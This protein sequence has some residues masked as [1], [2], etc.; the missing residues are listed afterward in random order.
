MTHLQPS[1]LLLPLVEP[2]LGGLHLLPVP[3]PLLLPALLLQPVLRLQL[4]EAGQLL[5]LQGQRALLLLLQQDVAA[6]AARQRGALRQRGPLELH[7]AV[8]LGDDG[9]GNGRDQG[10]THTHTQTHTH[11]HTD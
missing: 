3:L 10:H 4:V 11:T 1:A 2:S 9:L 7:V 6:V 5:A 8:L